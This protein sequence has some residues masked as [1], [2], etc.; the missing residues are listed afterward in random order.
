MSGLW[1]RVRSAHSCGAV[2]DFHRLPSITD[3]RI[4]FGAHFIKGEGDRGIANRQRTPF[5]PARSS[6]SIGLPASG[7]CL[8]TLLPTVQGTAVAFRVFV[9]VTA[10]GQRRIFTSLPMIEWP[11]LGGLHKLL[12]GFLQGLKGNDGVFGNYPLQSPL[13]HESHD[14]FFGYGG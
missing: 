5:P 9:P 2:P 6:P 13:G 7:S 3:T 8:L 1:G 12:G 14:V 11:Y 4:D 10:A